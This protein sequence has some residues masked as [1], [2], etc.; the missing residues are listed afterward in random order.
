MSL[1]ILNHGLYSMVNTSERT[2]DILMLIGELS[3]KTNCSRDT[4]RFYEKLG[5]IQGTKDASVS[6]NYKHYNQET[7]ER[8][9]LIKNAKVFG[10]T[11]NEIGK[12]IDDWESGKFTSEQKKEII[13]EK[14]QQVETKLEDLQKVKAYLVEKLSYYQ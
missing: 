13:E 9:E 10:F 3:E 12:L 5:L 6:N 1:T 11:L 14:L 8:I 2:K 4:L 7:V